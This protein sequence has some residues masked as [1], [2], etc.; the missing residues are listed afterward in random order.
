MIDDE[1][2]AFSGSDSIKR[3]CAWCGCAIHSAEYGTACRSCGTIEPEGE[4]VEML[5][6]WVSLASA[7]LDVNEGWPESAKE[8]L[9]CWI[10]EWKARADALRRKK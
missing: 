5:M 1:Q 10:A 8:P 3:E 2:R 9:R 7:V 6:Y 4:S